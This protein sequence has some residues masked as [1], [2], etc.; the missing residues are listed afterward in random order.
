MADIKK[1]LTAMLNRALELEHAARIQYLAHAE[2][3]KGINGEAVISRLKEIASDEQKHEEMFRDLIG[4]YLGAEPVMSLAETHK[5]KETR[6]ILEV[7]LKGEKDA[8]DF[9]KRIY[10][11]VM[12]NRK[13]FQYEF[14]TL[15]HNIRHVIIDEQEHVAELSLLLGI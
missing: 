6:K 2:L 14:E 13:S 4:S 1:E 10:Q 5:A 8:I 15:E 9:Y 11:K 12:D 3:I 7:N